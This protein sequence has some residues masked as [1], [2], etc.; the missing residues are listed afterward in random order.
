V[1]AFQDADDIWLP[2]KLERQLE[3]LTSDPSLEAVFSHV[4]QFVSADVPV[5]RVADLTPP[6][7]VL[8]GI[9]KITMLIRRQ[10][11]D[12]VGP[13]NEARTIVDFLDWYARAQVIGLKTRMLPDVLALRRLHLTNLGR[14]DT[15]R[16]DTE[17]L[18]SIKSFLDAKRQRRE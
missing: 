7:E 5:E 14:T 2:E 8:A 1:L 13:F 11:F 12:R 10:A 17:N 4:R 15:S 3:A 9:S 6:N 18:A 16:R